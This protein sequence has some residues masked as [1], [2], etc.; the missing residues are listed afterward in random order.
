MQHPQEIG[1]GALVSS[2]AIVP[3]SSNT[4]SIGIPKDRSKFVKQ[5]RRQGISCSLSEMVSPGRAMVAALSLLCRMACVGAVE[6][7]TWLPKEG[8]RSVEV[9]TMGVEDSNGR[10]LAVGN[11]KRGRRLAHVD[12]GTLAELKGTWRAQSRPGYEHTYCDGGYLV[13]KKDGSVLGTRVIDH[14]EKVYGA[15]SLIRTPVIHY[16]MYLA[17]GDCLSYKVSGTVHAH[18]VIEASHEHAAMMVSQDGTSICPKMFEDGVIQ[19]TWVRKTTN[20]TDCPALTGNEHDIH[21]EEANDG[22]CKDLWNCGCVVRNKKLMFCTA[23]SPY[24]S[25]VAQSRDAKGEVVFDDIHPDA[26]KNR[27]DLRVLYLSGNTELDYTTVERE[28]VRPP[29]LNHLFLYS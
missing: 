19:D 2:F 12:G 10:R 27:K 16:N 22:W 8:A 25:L 1:H 9:P 18:G 5:T 20:T 13:I 15:V 3:K 7:D 14:I 17:P 26:F 23:E 29:S 6:E 11:E 21:A 28:L 4:R 24:Y